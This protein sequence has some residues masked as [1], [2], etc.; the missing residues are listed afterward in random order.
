MSLRSLGNELEDLKLR[1][2]EVIAASQVTLGLLCAMNN[3]FRCLKSEAQVGSAGVVL[4][5]FTCYVNIM[6]TSK[7]TEE[8]LIAHHGAAWVLMNDVLAGC[9]GCIFD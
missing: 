2:C 7:Q 8:V 9:V 3:A 5:T 1:Y 4:V 6:P